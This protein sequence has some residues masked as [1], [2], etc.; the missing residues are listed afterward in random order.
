MSIQSVSGSDST[1]LAAWLESISSTNRTT[2]G[3]SSSSQ[4]AATGDSSNISNLSQLFSQL[5]SLASSDPA[6]FK[7]VTGEIATRLTDAA[8][9]AT[10]GQAEAL[11][12]MAEQFTKAS[13]S[14]KAEDLRP[15]TA[16]GAG[17]SHHRHHTH[18][19]AAADTDGSSSTTGDLLTQIFQ[20]ALGT[21]AQASASQPAATA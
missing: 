1:S 9:S 11:N 6:R 5:D 7:A 16:H 3:T 20:D 4:A 17:R 21:A 12:R 19:Q 10:G 2:V 8:G 18:P 13:E 14:G 15:P